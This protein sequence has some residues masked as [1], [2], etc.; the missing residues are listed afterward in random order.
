MSYSILFTRK[1]QNQYLKSKLTKVCLEQETESGIELT[2]VFIFDLFLLSTNFLFT[3][4][5]GDNSACLGLEIKILNKYI[6][7]FRLYIQFLYFLIAPFFLKFEFEQKLPMIESHFSGEITLQKIV[8]NFRIN[9][10]DYC[11]HTSILKFD[12][13]FLILLFLILSLFFNQLAA[14][15]TSFLELSQYLMLPAIPDIEINDTDSI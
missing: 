6:F 8:A 9:I 10:P 13:L 4:A 5:L 1:Y 14:F 7:S 11:H 12:S 2:T 15:L 3:A